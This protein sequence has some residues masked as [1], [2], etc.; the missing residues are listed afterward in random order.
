MALKSN[1]NQFLKETKKAIDKELEKQQSAAKK[2]IITA[3]DS[4]VNISP[5]D[6]GLF[7]TSNII[8][9]NRV[10]D[11]IFKDV[12]QSRLSASKAIVGA[13]KFNNGDTI[14]IQNNLLYGP[15]IEAGHSK[16]A[17]SGVYGVTEQRVKGLLNLKIK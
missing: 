17:P 7:R 11:T 9:Y 15:K 3:Y 10:D 4:I 8:T 13:V 5:V 1:I 14:T 2:V 16:Q 12:N 6:K